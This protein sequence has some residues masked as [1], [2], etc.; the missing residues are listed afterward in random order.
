MNKDFMKALTKKAEAYRK[1][2][3]DKEIAEQSL[4][5][6]ENRK[7]KAKYTP[8]FIEI[9]NW[10]GLPHENLSQP[11]IQIGD[12]T[13]YLGGTYKFQSENFDRRNVVLS[14]DP[15]RG[16][17]EDDDT[18]IR[19]NMNEDDPGLVALRLFDE[20]SATQSFIAHKTRTEY[21]EADTLLECYQI[22][23]TYAHRID[24]L[25]ENW[26]IAAEYVAYHPQWEQLVLVIRWTRKV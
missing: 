2:R 8:I 6:E 13:I 1:F 5:D 9:L 15:K 18:S 21:K 11:E 10:L 17:W 7:E 12:V 22:S 26:V 23:E 16:H 4:L 20:I 25:K 19:F 3:H 24:A 14:I